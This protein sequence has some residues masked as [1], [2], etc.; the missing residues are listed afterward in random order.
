MNH[1]NSNFNLMTTLN[2]QAQLPPEADEFS[3]GHTVV[4]RHQLLLNPPCSCEGADGGM[5]RGGG[6]R[7]GWEEAG[8][9]ALPPGC[10][11]PQGADSAGQ[12]SSI[13]GV[14]GGTGGFSPPV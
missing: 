4:D 10:P 1:F 3:P 12:S 9:T 14:S 6:S 2:S 13:I 11:Q 5:L 7:L 8:E